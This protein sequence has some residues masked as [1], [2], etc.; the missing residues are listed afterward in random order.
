MI[1]GIYL[2]NRP[3]NKWQLVSVTD[4]PESAQH[5]IDEALRQAK[6]EGHENAA[7]T[8]QTFDSSFYIPQYLDK[9]KEQK[10]MYN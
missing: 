4:S 10:L 7:A 8:F 5:D 2:R 9:V 6:L 1:H 3:K